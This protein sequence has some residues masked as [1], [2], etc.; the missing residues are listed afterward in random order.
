V[1]LRAQNRLWGRQVQ[2]NSRENPRYLKQASKRL[3]Q[4]SAGIIYVISN[5]A[6]PGIVKIGITNRDDIK[7]RL[8]ELFTTS[9]PVPFEC[10]YACKV[11]DVEKVEKAL[12][13]A[14]QNN[15][16]NPQREFFKIEPE[17]AI[18]VLKLLAVEDITPQ[19]V[20]DYEHDL[21]PSDAAAGK[22]LKQ[23][24]RPPLNFKE[25]NIP[26]GSI[27]KCTESDDEVEV[28]SER[29]VR[30]KGEET[31]LT[32]AI[33]TILKIDFAI[34]PTRYWTYNGKNLS[35]IYKETYGDSIP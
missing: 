10:E 20:R 18:A 29:K 28:I 12:H 11:N 24:R 13:I 2:P 14:F 16:V 7:Q 35:E 4:M 31:S 9:L 25:M 22:K 19:V 30:Y 8:R 27:L 5:P 26:I 32:N 17:Q 23:Q 21:N 1:S 15:R 3:A 33:K 6:M 34:H